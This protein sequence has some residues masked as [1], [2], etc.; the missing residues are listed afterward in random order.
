MLHNTKEEVLG[1]L[2]GVAVEPGEV[3]LDA[4]IPPDNN[5]LSDTEDKSCYLM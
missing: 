2:C 3:V 4:A 5:G 1:G